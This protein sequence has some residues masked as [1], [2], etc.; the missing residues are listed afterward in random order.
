MPWTRETL[1]KFI[2]AYAKAENG[3]VVFEGR[4]Y[5]TGFAKHLITHHTKQLYKGMKPWER[6]MSLLQKKS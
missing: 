3:E 4:N 1:E 2:D 5:D 6:T